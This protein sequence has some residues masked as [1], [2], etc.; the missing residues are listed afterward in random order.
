[1]ARWRATLVVAGLLAGLLV[2]GSGLDNSEEMERRAD[3]LREQIARADGR[4]P[5]GLLD[6]AVTLQQLNFMRP[7][8]GRRIAEAEKAYRCGA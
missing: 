8:G 3:V 7:D 1:M 6:L 4:D 5:G 2:E